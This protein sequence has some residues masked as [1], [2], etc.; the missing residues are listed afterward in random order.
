MTTLTPETVRQL[1]DYEAEAGNLIRKIRTNPRN[2]VDDIAGCLKPDGYLSVKIKYKDYKVH[3]LIWLWVH[4]CW[5]K[6]QIDHINGDRTDNRICNLREVTN[7]QNQMNQQIASN[8]NSGFCGVYRD[9][10]DGKW[11]AQ[12]RINRKN[13]RL[14]SFDHID[15]AKSVRQAAN[16]RYGFHS[17]HGHA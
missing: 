17:N 9:K 11:Y 4:N 15:D 16:I 2:N 7:Q 3:R 1:F 13:I 8:N 6:E 5:P 12:I 10:R 14:G